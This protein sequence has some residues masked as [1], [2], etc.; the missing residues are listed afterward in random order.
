MG[1]LH[2][3]LT[4]LNLSTLNAG[5]L[6]MVQK[7]RLMMFSEHGGLLHVL[8]F[9]VHLSFFAGQVGG[10]HS[11]PFWPMRFLVSAEGPLV[12]GFGVLGPGL[13]KN[14]QKKL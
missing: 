8:L 5:I 2:F 3:F 12:L 6:I 7:V 1:D 14:T 13:D 11:E 9:A 10:D 4:A